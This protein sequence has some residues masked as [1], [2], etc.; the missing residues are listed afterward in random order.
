[1]VICGGGTGGHIYPGLAV[2]DELLKQGVPVGWL[3]TA[4]GMEEDLVGK[5]SI[6]LVTVKYTMPKPGAVGRIAAALRVTGAAFDARA[7]LRRLNP[8][9]VLGLGGYPSLP[10]V[11]ATLGTNVKRVIH[12]QNV[13]PGAANRLLAPLAH[14]ILTSSDETFAGKAKVRNTGNPV[15][16]E[17]EGIA[18]PRQRYASRS[19]PLRLLVTGG[20]QGASS[21]NAALPLALAGSKGIWQVSHAAGSSKAAAKLSQEYANAKVKAEV[22]VFFDDMAKRMIDADLMVCR[23]GAATT[24]ELACVGLPSILIPYPHAGAHQRANADVL[25]KA[26]GALRME[27]EQLRHNGSLAELLSSIANRDKL[28]EMAQKTRRLQKPNSALE[29]ARECAQFLADV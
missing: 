8:R 6:G 26:G 21:L 24:A 13:L 17:F 3:G 7:M 2:A 14:R 23:A 10:G 27:D 28:Q 20:S 19:G 22:A 16:D 29:V 1:M 12:E 4:G 25:V 9:V 11:L 18:Q 15:R 5:T